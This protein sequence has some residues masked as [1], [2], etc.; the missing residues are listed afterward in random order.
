MPAE[1]VFIG[2]DV[3]DNEYWGRVTQEAVR[4]QD[5]WRRLYNLPAERF[6]LTVCRFV[7]KKNLPGLLRAYALY[8]CLASGSPWHLVI[9]GTGPME[10]EIRS[11]IAQLGLGELVHLPGYLSAEQ[12]G[13]LYALAS[14]FILPSLYSEQWGLVVNEAMAA[15]LPVLVSNICGCAP[16]LVIEGVT[17]F[18]FD[19]RD[20]RRLA[21]LMLRM[22]SGEVDLKKMGR[23]AQKHIANYSPDLFARNLL[24]AAEVAIEHA[25]RRRWFPWPP[26]QWW[27]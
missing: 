12:L 9:A 13:P 7:P 14:T 26:P 20:E 25:K 5:K 4:E 2:Y 6:F 10:E 16:D 23:A 24:Q 22:H 3:V 17:G 1:R 15:R 19:P 21:E 27:I 8:A 18:T 11:L